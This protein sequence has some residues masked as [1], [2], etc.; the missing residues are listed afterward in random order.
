MHFLMTLH[1]LEDIV[2]DSFLFNKKVS[3]QCLCPSGNLSAFHML[4]QIPLLPVGVGTRVPVLEDALADTETVGW[5][6]MV[7]LVQR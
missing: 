1:S 4:L 2:S 7:D 3:T 5:S 6:H